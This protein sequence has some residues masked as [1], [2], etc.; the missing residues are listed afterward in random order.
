MDILVILPLSFRINESPAFPF[1]SKIGNQIGNSPFATD[2]TIKGRK[3][4]VHTPK[5]P[6]KSYDLTM[7]PPLS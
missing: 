3:N 1:S 5:I 7:K 4:E 2:P 6:N